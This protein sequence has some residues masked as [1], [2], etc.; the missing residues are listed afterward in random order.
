MADAAIL[1]LNELNF[2]RAYPYLMSHISFYSH[3]RASL[4]GFSDISHIKVNYG[5]WSAI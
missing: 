3:G 1:N 5:R 4:H 2:F